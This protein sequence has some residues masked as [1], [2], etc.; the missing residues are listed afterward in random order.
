MLNQDEGKFLA[1]ASEFLSRLTL[2]VI[3][4]K[5]STPIPQEHFSRSTRYSPS[6]PRK[7]MEVVN[8]RR[9]KT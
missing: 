3:L 8:F 1:I 7:I 4:S 9:K 2:T 5:S 6:C